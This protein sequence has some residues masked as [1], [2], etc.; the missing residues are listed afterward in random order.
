MGPATTATAPVPLTT[1]RNASRNTTAAR[2]KQRQQQQQSSKTKT[3]PKLKPQLQHPAK[4]GGQAEFS[5]LQLA[6]AVGAVA[7]LALALIAAGCKLLASTVQAGRAQKRS[8][9]IEYN[10]ASPAPL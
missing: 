6:G 8:S 4:S 7:M 9:P 2:R 3:L 10:Y 1:K 5:R